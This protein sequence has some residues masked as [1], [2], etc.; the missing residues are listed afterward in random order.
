ME[1]D[2]RL[3]AWIERRARADVPENFADKVMAAVRE[4]ERLKRQ[5]LFMRLMLALLSTRAGKVGLGALA[6]LACAFRMMQVI[7]VF[8]VQ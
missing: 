1:P 2:D 8:F 3:E 6:V 5:G 4:S 7:G